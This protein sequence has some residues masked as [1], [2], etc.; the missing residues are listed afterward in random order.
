MR[1]KRSEQSDPEAI[2]RRYR[3]RYCG[4]GPDQRCI[5]T[6]G[7]YATYCHGDRWD[8]AINAGTLPIEDQE[9]VL[10]FIHQRWDNAMKGKQP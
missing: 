8:Q 5:T 10:D 3:C 4:A 6:S 9:D 7:R 2:M 1:F